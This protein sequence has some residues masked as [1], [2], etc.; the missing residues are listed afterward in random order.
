MPKDADRVRTKDI[1][2]GYEHLFFK[3]KKLI[4]F[5]IH[6]NGKVKEVNLR[7]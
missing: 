2:G 7:K 6:K 5:D 3:G 1:K 4:A